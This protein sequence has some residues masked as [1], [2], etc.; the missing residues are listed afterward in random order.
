[1]SVCLAQA[2]CATGREHQPHRHMLMKANVTTIVSRPFGE[3]T[4]VV[5]LEG[6][7]DC[8]VVD[9]GLEPQKIISALESRGLTPVA[10]LITHGH[11]DHI[12]GN[13]ALKSRWPDCPIVIGANEAAKL[14]DPVQNLSADF[15]VPI[16]SPPADRLVREGETIDYAGFTLEVR[17]IPGHSS[18]H[19]IYVW[20]EGDP[21]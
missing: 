6:R 20:R 1:M 15:G 8:L 11:S 10:F 17:E 16:T 12:G 5:W 18:G 21:S 4:Y 14:T 3:N 9:P 7:N 19:V 2:V 13:G